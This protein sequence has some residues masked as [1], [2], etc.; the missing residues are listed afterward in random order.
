[1]CNQK[2]HASDN[3]QAVVPTVSQ[4]PRNEGMVLESIHHQ[5]WIWFK[6]EGFPLMTCSNLYCSHSSWK[7]SMVSISNPNILCKAKEEHR[8]FIPENSPTRRG[9]IIAA[10]SVLHLI[11]SKIG[12]CQTTSIILGAFGGWIDTLNFFKIIKSVMDDESTVLERL[13]VRETLEIMVE[14]DDFQWIFLSW[15]LSWFLAN[16]ITLRVLI[17]AAVIVSLHWGF[18]FLEHRFQMSSI[19]WKFK[20]MF[21]MEANQ[22]QIL[23]A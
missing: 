16:Q 2:V 23:I 19:F 22:F 15:N 21:S 4:L 7:F 3:M 10:P 9:C 6:P 17:M 8:V 14:I 11:Q 1:M 13:L 18:Q 5:S 12:G 20:L